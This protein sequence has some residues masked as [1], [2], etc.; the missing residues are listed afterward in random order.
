MAIENR[1]GQATVVGGRLVYGAPKRPQFSFLRCI[2]VLS[3]LFYMHSSNP[4]NFYPSSQH[5]PPGKQPSGPA[6]RVFT[7]FYQLIHSFS[8]STPFAKTTASAYERR[9]TTNYWLFS[10][11][12]RTTKCIVT[13]G[14]IDLD[15]Y[16]DDEEFPLIGVTICQ[17]VIQQHMTHQKPLFY[18]P[19]DY[20]YTTHR[21]IAWTLFA[22]AVL[23]FCF[24]NPFVVHTGFVFLDSL[25]TFLFSRSTHSS[26]LSLV[27]RLVSLNVLIYP[28]LQ[29]MEATVR[30]QSPDSFFVLSKSDERVNFCFSLLIWIALAV[31]VNAASKSWTGEF[32]LQFHAL[33]AVGMGY[34]ARYQDSGMAPLWDWM[35]EPDEVHEAWTFITWTMILILAVRSSVATAV[36]WCLAHCSGQ[37]LYQYQYDHLVLIATARSV[38]HWI[39]SVAHTTYQ[40][41]FGKPHYHQKIA[42]R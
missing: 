2:T 38:T 12:D 8:Q 32:L 7:S 41:L 24:T 25:A 40:M 13:V 33:T 21:G 22:A 18:H 42:Y 17:N 26:F 15:C 5:S 23:S 11:K 31:I 39:N 9:R 6:A 14:G 10:V 19:K 20:A 29:A 27:N 30:Q 37:M 16:Y 1:S 28:V 35:L 3:I 4:A 34:F 36:F